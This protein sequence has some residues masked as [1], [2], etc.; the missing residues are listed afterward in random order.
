M[1]RSELADAANAYVD[2][3]ARHESSNV[4]AALAPHGGEVEPYTASQAFACARTFD[5]CSAWAYCGHLEDGRAFDRY[6]VSSIVLDID[7]F[8]HLREV[9]DDVELGVSFHGFSCERTDVY[10]GGSVGRSIRNAVAAQISESTSLDVQVATLGDGLF[11]RYGGRSPA[12]VVNRVGSVGGI[13]LEQTKAARR[14]YAA[15]IATSVATVLEYLY[16]PARA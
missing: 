15:E 11:R 7:R 4:A 8:E 10:V 1:N 3:Y 12:N 9:A 6:H 16:T 5:L 2:E 13:Q 14:E